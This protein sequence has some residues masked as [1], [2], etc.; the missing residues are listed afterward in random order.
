MASDRLVGI[1]STPPLHRGSGIVWKIFSEFKDTIREI[2]VAS[3]T[4]RA[5]MDSKDR[6]QKQGG[7][8]P[9]SID[10]MR[11]AVVGRFDFCVDSLA[12]KLMER[13]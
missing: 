9:Y 3:A 2:A 8:K 10:C 5:R 6:T 4:V 7:N 12:A 11:Q 13:L 1:K